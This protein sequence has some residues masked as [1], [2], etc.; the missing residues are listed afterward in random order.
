MR[1]TILP[2]QLPVSKWHERIGD[3]ML[4]TASSTGSCTTPT[5][6]RGGDSM[7]KT[8]E[9]RQKNFSNRRLD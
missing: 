8:G 2:S 7:R 5:A 3:P 4:A 6:L 1:S 9:N